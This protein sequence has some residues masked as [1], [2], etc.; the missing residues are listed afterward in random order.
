M[1]KLTLSLNDLLNSTFED[2]RFKGKQLHSGTY[3]FKKD[4]KEIKKIQDFEKRVKES[5]EK[6]KL[7]KTLTKT[8]T[9]TAK[10]LAFGKYIDKTKPKFIHNNIKK[11]KSLDDIYS[12]LRSLQTTRPV[13]KPF[14]FGKPK[15]PEVIK[16]FSPL[17]AEPNEHILKNI[18]NVDPKLLKLIKPDQKPKTI[19]PM[20]FGKF[21]EQKITYFSPA[22][23][24][25]LSEIL[26]DLNRSSSAS[27]KNSS[28][29][30]RS[31]K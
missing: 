6:E 11:S 20:K 10:P 5:I 14:V 24:Q 23:R 26:R 1:S 25:T 30:S 13:L 19:E 21:R 8:S 27:L 28:F 9:K 2:A 17:K 4:E 12:S 29:S 22:K 18:K 16:H 15:K 7:V 3:K 31:V